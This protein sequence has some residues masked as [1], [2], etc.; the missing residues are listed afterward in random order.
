ML[1]APSFRSRLKVPE[2]QVVKIVDLDSL[3]PQVVEGS[4]RIPISA[5][6]TIIRP[7]LK[8]TFEVYIA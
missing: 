7:G 4:L 2:A 6:C 1:I 5:Q 3:L 8:C